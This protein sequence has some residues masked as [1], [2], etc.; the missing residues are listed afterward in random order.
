MQIEKA[1]INQENIFISL[2]ADGANAPNTNKQR[3]TQQML[4]TQPNKLYLPHI[5]LLVVLWAFA[6]CV[7]SN[8][9]SCFLNLQVFFLFAAWWALSAMVETIQLRTRS[10]SFAIHITSE[11]D[12][13]AISVHTFI[14]WI[15]QTYAYSKYGRKI[16]CKMVYVQH[17]KNEAHG[18]WGCKTIK[19][20]RTSS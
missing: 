8:W 13:F 5:S 4:T 15:K 2:T 20:L 1:P 6:A 10:R 7:L 9:G 18:I 11:R 14:L 12:V 17:L 19:I 3:N 16:K